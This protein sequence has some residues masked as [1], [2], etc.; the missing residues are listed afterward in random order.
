M[1]KDY[2]P[3]LSFEEA[4]A[5]YQT[6]HLWTQIAGKIKLS[7]MPWINHS[8]HVTL[9]VSPSGLTT[10]SIPD[11]QQ[12]FQIN[13]DF[14]KHQLQ[15]ITSSG[16]ERS[17]ALT[18]LSVAACYRNLLGALQELGIEANINT[19]PNELVDP[20]PFH[21]DEQH[22][23]YQPLHAA[24]LH[25]A[26]LRANEVLNRFRAEFIGKCSPVHFFWGSFDLAVSRFS[27]RKAPAHPGGVP[28]LPDWVARE[29]YSHEVSSCG[30]WPGN[31]AV[32]YAA[33]YSYIYPEP[34]GYKSF[35]IKPSSGLYHK[36]L[37]EF[38][39][40]Y[41]EVQQAVNPTQTLLDFLQSTYEAA[42]ETANWDRESL[43]KTK[44]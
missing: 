41:K 1:E 14:I 44:E 32:P 28:N 42:A 23:T 5:T 19:M 8:W 20:I 21:Q 33:F 13:F 10:G 27:G 31:E 12:H 4:K 25:E 36:N 43:E 18:N 6:I 37:G 16:A 15:I 2:W 38:I 30:F 7:K 3:E 35:P 26:L 34:P 11:Q 39:L 9:S 40:P 29:A 17:F 24:N 22:H